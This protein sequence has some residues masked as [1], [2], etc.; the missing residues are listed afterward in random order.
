ML[1]RSIIRRESTRLTDPAPIATIEQFKSALL[2]ARDWNGIAPIQLQM[3]QAQC[4][5]PEC[6]ISASQLAQ[7]LSFKSSA[8]AR[9]QYGNFARA[10]ADKLGYAPPQKGKGAP[11]WWFTLSSGRELATET[12][13][14]QVELRRRGALRGA[15]RKRRRPLGRA[16]RRPRRDRREL[17][18][19]GRG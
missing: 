10:I 6:T 13:D 7:K 16:Q 17:V 5:A 18:R 1:T 4:G 3:L 15:P 19:R 14:G 2:A 12:G 8:A 9:L 11:P